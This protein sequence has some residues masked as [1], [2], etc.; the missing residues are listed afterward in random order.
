M[1]YLVNSTYF[2]LPSGLPR[3]LTLAALQ[4]IDLKCIGCDGEVL[5]IMRRR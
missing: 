1:T 4:C 2:G 3:Q 5:D